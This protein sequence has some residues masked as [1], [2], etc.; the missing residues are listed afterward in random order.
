MVVK[1]L[2]GMR[3]SLLVAVLLLV[4][5]CGD[6]SDAA[7]LPSIEDIPSV[8][9]LVAEFEIS[10]AELQDLQWIAGEEGWTLQEA[11]WR[12]QWQQHFGSV[13]HEIRE[14]YPDQF[15][16][17]GILG[18][19]GPRNVYIAFSGPVPDDVRNDPRLDHLDVEFR[20]SAG[21]SEAELSDQVIDVHYTMRDLG[22]LEIGTGPD[23]DTG[24]VRVE[25]AR[26]SI[27]RGKTDEE[28]IATL[29]PN[30]RADNVV[31][32]FHP[33]GTVLNAELE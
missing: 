32:V 13:L 9:E 26:R 15:A 17:G 11:I 33:E 10:E 30:V 28:I 6:G 25:A 8:E 27:D 4:S 7:G 1:R 24:Q 21:F 31:I 2:I 23:I 14:T 16:G 18:E 12:I 22:F 29:P 20:E 5:G 19:E 3:A